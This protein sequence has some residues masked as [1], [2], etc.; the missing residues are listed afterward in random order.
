MTNNTNNTNNNT[1]N[2]NNMNNSSNMNT[3]NINK[4][5]KQQNIKQYFAT[6]SNFFSKNISKFKLPSKN[7]QQL[8]PPK[9]KDRKDS[10]HIIKEK[11]KEKNDKQKSQAISTKTLTNITANRDKEEDLEVSII[12]NNSNVSENFNKLMSK[13]YADLG[14]L[15]TNINTKASSKIQ[16]FYYD[17]DKKF[18]TGFKSEAPKEKG[19]IYKNINTKIKSETELTI[20]DKK[21]FTITN[22]IAISMLKRQED[23][24]L[25]FL[26]RKL[27]AGKVKN[28]NLYENKISNSKNIDG[29]NSRSRRKKEINS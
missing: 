4:E 7:E 12:S 8:S 27:E 5:N 15:N 29:N 16:I 22:P 20:K 11:E 3:E 26:R 21:L 18:L 9:T 10:K 19:L 6:S 2:I 23:L 13:T 1:S 14:E 28:K 17:K 24:D 25:K